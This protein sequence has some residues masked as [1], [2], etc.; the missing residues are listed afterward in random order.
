MFT[1]QT[2]A[3]KAV[4]QLVATAPVLHYYMISQKKSRYSAMHL[5]RDLELLY[6]NKDNQLLLHSGA[7]LR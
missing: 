3:F 1:W 6:Y 2:A 4:K 7:Y 5:R